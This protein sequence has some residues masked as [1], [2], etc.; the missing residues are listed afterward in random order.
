MQLRTQADQG[1]KTVKRL[2]LKQCDRELRRGY[3]DIDEGNGPLVRHCRRAVMGT[4][5]GVTGLDHTLTL[6]LFSCVMLA[7]LLSLSEP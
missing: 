1:E 6:L 7:Q 3:Q 2:T 4:V 5:L